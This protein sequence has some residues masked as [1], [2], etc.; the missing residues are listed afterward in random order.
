MELMEHLRGGY[1]DNVGPCVPLEP[2]RSSALPL[3]ER[4]F[5]GQK[6]AVRFEES[7][8]AAKRAVVRASD[9]ARRKRSLE[10]GGLGGVGPLSAAALELCGHVDGLLFELASLDPMAEIL[11][12]LAARAALGQRPAV[13]VLPA[14]ATAAQV[15]LFAALAAACDCDVLLP[16]G[17]SPQALEALAKH[18]SFMALVRE[19]YRPVL[20]LVDVEV[21]LS[22]S[23]DHWTQG[24]H[25]RA[26]AMVVGA[27]AR[28]QLQ[29]AVRLDLAGELRAPLLI[30][31]GAAALSGTDAAAARRH[32]QARGDVLVL[33][34]AL[35]LGREGHARDPVL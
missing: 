13:A 5:A 35:P 17:A 8:A 32:V 26:A 23:C 22:P 20:P 16:E 33:G 4:P 19:R 14:S 31:A 10:I 7:A 18:R 1:G 27:L 24:A 29:P 2:L 12:L 28:A 21:L 25:Q 9:E 30:L 11:P 34:P 3:R 15:R 6:E